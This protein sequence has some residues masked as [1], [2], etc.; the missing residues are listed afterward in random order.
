M[1]GDFDGDGIDGIVSRFEGAD[2]FSGM[3]LDGTTGDDTDGAPHPHDDGDA[4][5]GDPPMMVEEPD[6]TAIE[7]CAKLDVSDTDHAKRLMRHR[8]EDIC[9]RDQLGGKET[10]WCVWTGTHWNDTGGRGP[11]RAIAQTIGDLVKL[12][13]LYLF[14]T[15][16]ER[17]ALTAAEAAIAA[18]AKRG[19]DPS[20]EEARAIERGAMAKKALEK[21][22]GNRITAGQS[23]KN[24]GK[25]DAMLDMAAPHLVKTVDAF[26]FDPLVV[27]CETHTLRFVREVA[28]GC[29]DPIIRIEAEEGHSRS[30]MVTVVAPVAWIPGAKGVALDA[31]LT[32]FMPDPPTRTY[33][34]KVCGLGV[35]GLT[36]QLFIYHWGS[37]ANGKSV[38]LE[39]I[40][41]V[42]GAL[43]A[44]LPAG[45]ISGEVVGDEVKATPEIARL[46]ATRFVK[47]T[48]IEENVSIRESALKRMTG[49]ERFPARNLFEGYF[50]FKPIFILHGSG[51][52]YPRI[53]GV[54][55]GIK[56]RV[57][58]IK[59]PVQLEEHEKRNF[60]DVVGELVAEGPALFAWLVEGARLY[61]E[62]GLLTPPEVMMQTSKLFE[63][64]DPV[65][66][67]LDQAIEATGDQ[68][69]LIGAK[70]LYEAFVN[71]TAGNRSAVN[72]TRFGL[73]LKAILKFDDGDGDAGD[74]RKT[75]KW[76]GSLDGAL[77]VK[78]TS[79]GLVVY[80]GLRLRG[81][82]GD[83]GWQPF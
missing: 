56:R 65:A 20:A 79:S 44:T 68:T 18:A 70:A 51:N 33:F 1:S 80:R 28:E 19:E 63:A 62:E 15:P 53:V 17:E 27:A 77:V 4:T 61:L 31:F 71:F 64:N 57:R 11:A 14:P 39:A 16:P 25:V 34:Q 36:E 43:A 29:S 42:L 26:N 21:R 10:L 6:W 82:S 41:R 2:E 46:F 22:K 74:R 83:P 48:E 30:D 23:A 67:F 54:D 73:N 66:E 76:R 32:R 78:D 55:N 60:E 72:P 52:G 37:G 35:L 75:T 69:D 3:D 59:W 58:V 13:A 40:C 12:E 9:A 7:E 49:G 38:F 5:V 50:D 81:R 47:V 45:A 8:G 24:K